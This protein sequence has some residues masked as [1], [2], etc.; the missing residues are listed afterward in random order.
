MSFF[1]DANFPLKE[2]AAELVGVV[3]DNEQLVVA[4]AVAAVVATVVVGDIVVA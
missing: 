2:V 3:G 4:A 1:A